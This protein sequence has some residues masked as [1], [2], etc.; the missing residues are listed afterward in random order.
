MRIMN[1]DPANTSVGGKKK[2][3]LTRVHVASHL[4]KYRSDMKCKQFAIGLPLPDFLVPPP[5]R[6][7]G[8]SS[9]NATASAKAASSSTKTAKAN[10]E[11][12]EEEEEE[13]EEYDTEL[14][15]EDEDEEEEVKEPKSQPQ[16]K[17]EVK[18]PKTEEQP[19][20]SAK[21]GHYSP[22]EGSSFDSTMAS[23]SPVREVVLGQPF[24]AYVEQD[25]YPSHDTQY[26]EQYYGS[27]YNTKDGF[28][29][30]LG[31][32]HYNPAQAP[33]SGSYGSYSLS[34]NNY[35]FFNTTATW[36]YPQLSSSTS[37]VATSA[38]V[39]PSP[40]APFA[41]VHWNSAVGSVCCNACASRS[42]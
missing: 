36:H 3:Q 30:D 24:V 26:Y 41:P 27:N 31:D 28:T 17:K 5:R 37:S 16:E 19:S 14:E 40:P 11:L 6:G 35:S 25:Y 9:S 22:F 42:L 18:R 8:N 23:P 29:F 15:E 2:F 13:E 39:T 12:D 21:A 10:Q 1:N 7:R 38:T 20:P 33:S 4:Q 32:W 34:Q